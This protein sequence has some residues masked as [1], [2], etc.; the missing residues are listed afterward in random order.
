MSDEKPSR[1]APPLTLPPHP[2]P[3]RHQQHQQHRLLRRLRRLF[4]SGGTRSLFKKAA[5]AEQKVALQQQKEQ[6]PAIERAK[7]QQAKA[8]QA[9][10]RAE[11]EEASWQAK[12]R[13]QSHRSGCGDTE[14]AQG[15]SLAGASPG[16]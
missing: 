9:E 6:Q 2:L 7:L 15:H 16:S 5:T 4:F 3:Q 14:R 11:D 13:F 10:R 8:Q 12:E 1:P